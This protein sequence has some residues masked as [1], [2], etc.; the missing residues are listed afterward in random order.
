MTAEFSDIYYL[1]PIIFISSFVRSIAG[2]GDALIAM[3]LLSLIIGVKNA[4]PLAAINSFTISFYLLFSEKKHLNFS[5]VKGL[6]I[7][8][9]AGIPIGLFFLKVVPE[10]I[11]NIILGVFI[12]LFA[13]SNLLNMI[14]QYSPPK[15]LESIIGILTGAIGAAFNTNGPIIVAWF[16][17][18][19]VSKDEFRANL[20][21]V[22]LPL[23]VM[24]ILSHGVVGMWYSDLL[25][26][27]IIS[28][29]T[30]YIA[31]LIGSYIVKFISETNF[32][33]PVLFLLIFLGVNLIYNS[34]K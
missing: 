5:K 26:Y 24:V 27:A 19:G 15:Y 31:F 7:W 30:I 6:I 17:M 4:T 20:Q 22:F 3:P 28:A 21:A 25:Y 9:I 13:V 8:G 33:K 10:D 34:I 18:L 32:R 23:N 14:K 1:L 12:I 16:V 29:V 11:I 2:F